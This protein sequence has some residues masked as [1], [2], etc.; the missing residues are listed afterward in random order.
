MKL[1]PFKRIPV[2]V[3]CGT[4]LIC[5]G[6]RLGKP[7]LLQRFEN[8]TYD[9]RARHALKSSPQV[10][11][12]LGFIF[13]NEDSVSDVRN[14]SLGFHYGLLWPRQVY[15]RLIEELHQQGAKAV[16]FDVLF[17]ELRPDHPPV[18]LATGELIESDEFFAREMRRASNVIIA[19]SEDL[20]PPPLF[21]TN[22][23][24]MADISTDKDGDGILRRVRAFKTYRKWHHAFRQVEA[25]PDYGIDLRHARIERD[26]IL[27][28]RSEGRPITVPLGPDGSFD[29]ADFGGQGRA[30]PYTEERAWHM[31]VALAAL[32]L[33]LDLND[34]VV[35]TGRGTITLHGPGIE[36]VLPVDEQGF[37][38]VDWC[39]P[40]SHPQLT[41]ES[42]QD[43][44]RSARDRAAGCTNRPAERWAGKLAVVGSSAIVGNNLTD[45]G[46]TPLSKETL[47]VSKHWNVANSIITGRFV[48][49]SSLAVDL[50]C[51]ILLG[52][53]AGWVTWEFRALAGLGA[54]LA[55]SVAY[56]AV[57]FWVYVQN[58]YWMPVIIPVGVGVF[59][60]YASLIAWRVVF[61]EAQR[62]H[63]KSVF[64]TM[65]APEA[66]EELLSQETVELG[67]V[68][69]QVT[70]LFADVRGFTEFTDTS[71]C[72]VDEYVKQNG[73]TGPAAA[74]CY[75][76]QARETLDTINLYL[77]TVAGTILKQH[78]LLDKFIGDCVMAF[79]GAPVH[80]PQHAAACIRG[81]I[82]AQ[83]AV[84]ELNRRRH[85]DN[86]KLELENGARASAGLPPKPLLPILLLGS[87]INSGTVTLGVMRAEAG[88]VVRQGNYTVFGS[89]VNLA[90][91]L[92]GYSGRGRICISQA[93][94][95]LLRRDD[96]DLAATCI[97][98]PPAHLKGIR[99]E[100]R[101]YEVPWRAPGSPS[102]DEE[103]GLKP[104]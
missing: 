50:L 74:A 34:P 51:I 104:K 65:L 8:V 86:K 37:F 26:R 7:E 98:L 83:R 44:L 3:V 48:R 61:E 19:V 28:P 99:S 60:T 57:A 45:L 100:V 101:V 31:G 96:P 87:G 78:G 54:N 88:G 81:A 58:R 69:R 49:R 41:K 1:R 15:G 95:E 39:L 42:F 66:V 24:G 33:G 63:V 59:T 17:G 20:A 56:I 21:A 64:S 91:R 46:A 6:V 27:L 77:G 93:T 75:D 12:N 18:Q 53:A 9:M 97:E 16:A 103:F 30:R 85:A 23:L 52:T 73:L 89:D 14:G 84:Y 92:E 29:L 79:W 47:L 68:R 10:A 25:D 11:T 55:I 4:I 62:R 38:L 82:E 2:L 22:A 102:L 72:R 13:I 43:L 70:V 40:P 76:K 94:Y 71:Q 90:S 67:G 5:C 80:N 36:R 35:D 32:D